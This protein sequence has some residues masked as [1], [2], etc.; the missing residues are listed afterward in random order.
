MSLAGRLRHPIR[1]YKRVDLGGWP[2][3]VMESFGGF[4]EITDDPNYGHGNTE[5]GAEMVRS[6]EHPS[7]A[8]V[9]S[10][11]DGLVL[12]SPGRGTDDVNPATWRDFDG[13]LW[14]AVANA[15]DRPDGAVVEV[16]DW[17]E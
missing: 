10:W 16:W 4:R 13:R 2:G 17:R 3:L 8:G 9:A 15:K 5:N 14:D 11:G 6:W 1:G 12:V 7:G